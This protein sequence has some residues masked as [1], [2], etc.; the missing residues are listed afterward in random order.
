M[1]DCRQYRARRRAGAILLAAVVLCLAGGCDDGEEA[2]PWQPP[3]KAIRAAPSAQPRPAPREPFIYDPTAGY[4]AVVTTSLGTFRMAFHGTETPGTVRQF[5][6]LATDLRMYR[7]Q[8]FY[9]VSKDAFV[10]T[11]DASGVGIGDASNP[12]RQIPGEFTDRAF[13]AGTVGFARRR[14]N[15]NSGN[16]QWFVCLRRRPEWDKRFAAFA[17]VTEGLDVVRRISRVPVEGDRAIHWSRV[18]RPVDPP[19][20]KKI[21]IVKVTEGTGEGAGPFETDSPPPMLPEGAEYPKPKTD[22]KQ[23]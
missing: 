17:H 9:R 13:E 1:T 5:L 23:E 2:E 11:G 12:I 10:Q 4:E 6:W 16:T 15:P 19:V 7:G 8:V 22:A 3:L 20:I 14:D 18:E 21:E